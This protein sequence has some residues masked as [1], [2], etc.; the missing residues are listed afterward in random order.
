MIFFKKT[1]MK[2]ESYYTDL[3]LF[4][5]ATVIPLP[6]KLGMMKIGQN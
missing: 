6:T 1:E 4:F 3:F 2:K 5:M